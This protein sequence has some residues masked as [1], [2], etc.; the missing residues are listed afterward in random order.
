MYLIA[1]DFVPALQVV[2]V[3]REAVN[4]EE[5]CTTRCHS[6]LDQV[7]SDLNLSVAQWGVR[8]GAGAGAGAAWHTHRHD[9]A[10]L[11]V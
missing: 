3:A 11:D 1:H 8:G 9:T 4:E 6:L 7:H 5:L 10:I 2:K